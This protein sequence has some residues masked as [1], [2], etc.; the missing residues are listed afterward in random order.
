[1]AYELYYW[2][3]LQGRGEFVRLALEEAGADYVDIALLPESR[4]GGVAA[5]LR[6]M[7][8]E[9]L[10]RPPFAPPFLKVGTRYIAQTSHHPALSRPASRARAAR[11]RGAT[12]DRSAATHDLATSSARCT[13][14]II[15]SA[16]VSTTS[17]K[18][19]PR[20][21]VPGNSCCQRLPK[22]LGYFEQLLERNR[23]RGPWLV[24]ARL[25]LRRFVDGAGDR[26][27]CATRSRSRA[28][29]C[30]AR[31]RGCVRCSWPRSRGRVSSAI[32][33]RDVG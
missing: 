8:D 28:R 6:T 29:A 27:V 21:G 32:S 17:S 3:G 22:F 4:G 18:S 10:E 14:R 23:A 1:M 30:C 11:H 12:L 15:R 33:P 25:T 26:R 16:A 19:Q 24:G 13:T 20:G 7:Q 9:R 2:P 31:I 5:L